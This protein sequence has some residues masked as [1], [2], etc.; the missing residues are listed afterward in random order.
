MLLDWGTLWETQLLSALSIDSDHNSWSFEMSLKSCSVE[1]YMIVF[2]LSSIRKTAEI[3]WH[4]IFLKYSCRAFRVNPFTLR[5]ETVFLCGEFCKK[6]WQ[7]SSTN[8]W[9]STFSTWKWS[10][11]AGGNDEEKQNEQF[12]YVNVNLRE[13]KMWKAFSVKQWQ[14]KECFCRLS[15]CL[16]RC[17]HIKI[18]IFDTISH[19]D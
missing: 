7:H 4:R 10:F 2:L 19:V 6:H 1:T 18:N 17:K 13:L 5:S 14:Q 3:T 11:I 8:T 9:Y 15:W 16:W 12:F